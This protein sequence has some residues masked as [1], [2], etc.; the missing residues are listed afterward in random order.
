MWYRLLGRIVRSCAILGWLL[1]VRGISLAQTQLSPLL[2]AGIDFV[3][4]E[5]YDRFGN[6]K[7]SATMGDA[8][9]TAESQDFVAVVPEA[10]VGTTTEARPTFWFHVPFD[11]DDF[12]SM[13]FVL[14][15]EHAN[16]I[17]APAIVI[18]NES[19]PGIVSFPLPAAAGVLEPGQSYQV[20]LAIFCEDPEEILTPLSTSV[21]TWVL[22]QEIGDG[23]QRDLDAAQTE[24]DKVVVY[25]N[26]GIWHEALTIVGRFGNQQDWDDLMR[27]PEVGLDEAADWPIVNCCAIAPSN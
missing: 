17:G 19:L 7:G 25:A 4:I 1:A 26:H 20:D 8:C 5:E 27:D 6:R 16:V 9:G 15:D 18:K 21:R 22:R 3:P 12:H 11:S 14:L 23:L 24:G 2:D 10:L 13:E